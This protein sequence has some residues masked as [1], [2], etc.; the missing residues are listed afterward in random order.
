[1]RQTI[2]KYGKEAVLKT[3]F[4]ENISYYFNNTEK[5]VDYREI[6]KVIELEMYL[7]LRMEN[8]LDLPV[9]KAGFTYGKWDDFIPYFK[10]KTGMK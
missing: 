6:K 4:G 1:M 5:T 7:I 10:Q 3:D 9:W 8:G 2:E